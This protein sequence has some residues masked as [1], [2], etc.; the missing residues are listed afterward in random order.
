MSKIAYFSLIH[1]AAS[2]TAT[3]NATGFPKENLQ[4][5]RDYTY[6][7]ATG[8]F[9]QTIEIDMTGT[10]YE[11]F[12]VSYFGIASHNLKTSDSEISLDYWDG[13]EWVNILTQNAPHNFAFFVTFTA[14]TATKYRIGVRSNAVAP[15]V[16]YIGL[17]VVLDMVYLP[18][19]PFNLGGERVVA[20]QELSNT[21]NL[22]GVTIDYSEVDLSS[23]WSPV[24]SA[25]LTSIETF[26]DNHARYGRPF[27]YA[28]TGDTDGNYVYWAHI[29]ADQL[30][31]SKPRSNS[32]F[33]DSITF[34][35]VGHR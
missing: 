22:L 31:I 3:S 2:I 23:T 33:T 15:Q 7:K 8:T 21:G 5:E 24:S 16:G 14:V 4:D 35:I 26:W 6:W 25:V 11:A 20:T 13:S 18:N 29:P 1:V 12:P 32:V 10:A 34:N 19:A 28:P 17:G 9:N 27:F 30:E